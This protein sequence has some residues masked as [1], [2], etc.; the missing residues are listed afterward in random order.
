MY[1]PKFFAL[2]KYLAILVILGC[3]VSPVN[4]K[5]VDVK[6]LQYRND[7]AYAVRLGLKWKRKSDGTSKHGSARDRQVTV[8][9]TAIIRLSQ[10]E[11]KGLSEGD[12]VWL[13]VHIDSGSTPSCRKSEKMIYSKSTSNTERFYTLGTTILNN[14]CRRGVPAK[15]KRC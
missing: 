7:G 3:P 10:F 2:S 9:Q 14:R 5:N 8:C 1:K 15:W 12:E 4:A 6:K 11:R 13:V